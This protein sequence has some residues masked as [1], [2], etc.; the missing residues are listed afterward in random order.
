MEKICWIQ[1]L[2]R[3]MQTDGKLQKINITKLVGLGLTI[4]VNKN[5]SVGCSMRS[6]HY[7]GFVGCLLCNV[8]SSV[9]SSL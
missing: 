4:S 7:E 6:P 5:V 1:N 9:F 3:K 8:H 2:N